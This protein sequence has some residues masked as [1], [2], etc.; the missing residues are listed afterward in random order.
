MFYIAARYTTRGQD[1]IGEI[2]I[3][4][5]RPAPRAGRFVSCIASRRPS[6]RGRPTR[7]GT[8]AMR[9][10]D[11]SLLRPT[12]RARGDRPGVQGVTTTTR[13]CAVREKTKSFSFYLQ[14]F[15]SLRWP[16]L[17]VTRENVFGSFDLSLPTNTV[18]HWLLKL[19]VV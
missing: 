2:I 4:I 11:T 5:Y 17:C 3:T 9:R 19:R 7:D 8:H 10:R 15:G 16:L 18:R 13:P 1:E 6:C 12:V 14:V